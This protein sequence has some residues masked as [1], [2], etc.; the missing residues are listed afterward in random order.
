M[1]ESLIT[2]GPGGTS[3][4]GPDA[5]ALFRAAT[6]ASALRIFAKTRTPVNRAYTSTAMLK[7]ASEL[8]GKTYKRGQYQQ[9]AADIDAW[10][11]VMKAAL[12]VVEG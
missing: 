5:V 11:L 12:P 1:T 7:F 4:S 10:C 8:T 9:A 2:H 6:I 3:F